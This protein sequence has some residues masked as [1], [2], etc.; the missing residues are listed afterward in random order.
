MALGDAKVMAEF[1]L[2]G[3]CLKKELP[4]IEIKCTTA[5]WSVSRC[6]DKDQTGLRGFQ[7]P[8]NH[9]CVMPAWV[10]KCLRREDLS[11]PTTCP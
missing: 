3:I 7:L 2:V 1:G 10:F 11:V 5:H 9:S 6:L 4:N 8:I